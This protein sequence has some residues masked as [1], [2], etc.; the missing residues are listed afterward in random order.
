MFAHIDRKKSIKSNTEVI[1]GSDQRLQKSKKQGMFEGAF[2]LMFGGI[3]VKIIGA[4]FKIPLQN[5]IGDIGTTYFT[6]AYEIYTWMYIIATAGLPVA[7]SRMISSYNAKGRPADAL[8]TLRVA[9]QA[10]MVVGVLCSVAMFFFAGPLADMMNSPNSRFA[11]MAIAPSIMFEVAMACYLGFYQGE[12]NMT[13]TAISQIIVAV[14]KLVFGIILTVAVLRLVPESNELRIPLAAAGAIAGVTIGTLCS[15][16]FLTIKFG[17]QKKERKAAVRGMPVTRSRTLLKKLVFISV[18]I[19]IGASVLSITNLVDTLLLMRRLELTGMAHME[20]EA[21]YGAYSW[22]RTMF[23][24]PTALIVP[25]GV[26]VVPTITEQFAL[27]RYGLA[28]TYVDSTL[29]VASLLA[30]PAGVGL[31]VLSKP[32]LSLLYPTQPA[33][34]ATAAPLLTELGPAVVLVCFVSITNALLQAM[35]RERVPIITMLVGGSLK[36]F[37][38]YFLVANPEIGIN[39]AP[40]GTNLCYG[41]IAIL[42]LIIISKEL[43]KGVDVLGALLKPL[44]SAA[45]CGVSAFFVYQWMSNHFGN[46]I[47]VFS[48]IAVAGIVYIVL[49]LVLKTLRRVDI[50][51]FPKAAKIEKILDKFGWIG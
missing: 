43:G 27:K 33:G 31:A 20:I 38:N 26:A 21:A 16:T 36:V 28:K 3:L 14:A 9:F 45:A 1:K 6:V 37:C 29:R 7:I 12:K 41:T 40:L 50:Q 11:I 32:I 17:R 25:L 4:M 46:F 48:A 22:A 10:F 35:G 8:R 5:L 51:M 49:V 39:G 23:N 30:I 15:M 19:T 13:P 44:I 42:N 34:V 24:L 2:I 47:S 18:P